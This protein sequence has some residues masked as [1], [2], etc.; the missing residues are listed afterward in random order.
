MKTLRARV[1]A[2]TLLAVVSVGVL[3]ATAAG[4][5]TTG[6]ATP[7]PVLSVDITS[8][9]ASV[10]R[11][12]FEVEIEFA[13]PVTGFLLGEID[14]ANGEA[15]NLE[16]S[17]SG[18][19]VLITPARD[20]SVAVR[21]PANAGLDSAGRGNMP[22]SRFM[23]TALMGEGASSFD[24][25]GPWIN[26]WDRAA[27][28]A[29]YTQ[30]YDRTEPDTGY[31]GNVADCI[32]GTTSQ[33][34]RDSILQRLNWFRR[35]AGVDVVAERPAYTS[36]AQ[37]AALIMAAAADLSHFPPS[38]WS[39]Y[40][41]QG[42][43]GASKSNLHIRSTTGVWRDREGAA[44]IDGYMHDPGANNTSV[45]HRRWIL[46]PFL[47]DIGTGKAYADQVQADALYVVGNLRRRLD[48]VR[49]ARDVMAWP[50]PGYVP[51][52]T[53]WQRWSFTV[54]GASDF[55][56]AAVEVVG[57]TGPIAVAIVHRDHR[58]SRTYGVGAAI[59]WELDAIDEYDSMREPTDGD[60]CY[61]VTVSGV[62]ISGVVQE[63]F[64][65]STCVLDLS[66]ESLDGSGPSGLRGIYGPQSLVAS[67]ATHNSATLSWNLATQ[68][69]G[70]S[71]SN[72]VLER[73]GGAGW[74]TVHSSPTPFT[75][76]TVDG[77]SPSTEYRFRVRLTTSRGDAYES[78]LVTTAGAPV[79]IDARIVARRL[80]DGR[81]E[82]ALQQRRSDGQWSDRQLPRGRF[83]PAGARPGRW[84]ASTPLTLTP[85]SSAADL[86][87]MDVPVRIVARRL[88]DGRLEFALQ[89]RREDGGW[90]DRQFPRARFLPTRA[91][92]GRWLASSAM[93]VAAT[94]PAPPPVAVIVTGRPLTN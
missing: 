24:A 51:A 58:N 42:H 29:A 71:V 34:F 9:A 75:G 60:Q 39:C 21:I 53:V 79:E 66:I 88:T 55:S 74:S 19:R 7:V 20:G 70:V 61:A 84:L 23:R 85:G 56:D 47:G 78:I 17:G 16:G 12:P 26:T 11:A 63:P 32:A 89:Q 76:Y 62:K 30:E 10:V 67:R 52:A 6:D 15:S 80:A 49:E 92:V 64:D 57:E 28:L 14:V 65:Y 33:E 69:A 31:T 40:T 94:Q 3:P 81:T 87:A 68:P 36:D 86:A 25:T 91:G 50:P 72:Y 54:F 45:G 73:P 41:Q 93:T 22:S 8:T 43:R 37:H 18:Y 38:S 90:G 59:V 4:Q 48:D 13:R 35:L 44:A 83:F 1:A 46:S 27:V 5:E 82:F 77:L 2:A